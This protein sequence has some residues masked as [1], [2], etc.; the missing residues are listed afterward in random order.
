MN[1]NANN[2]LAI[3]GLVFAYMDTHYPMV[4][5]QKLDIKTWQHVV[6]KLPDL[7]ISKNVS[8]NYNNN[9]SGVSISGEFLSLVASAI[10]TDGASLLVDFTSFLNSV[11]DAVF[12]AQM[13]SESYKALTCTYQSYIKENALGGYFDY[14]AIVLRQIEFSEHFMELKG[15]CV[16]VK[17][18]SV[19]MSYVESTCLVQTS[20]IREGGHDYESFQSLINK[21]STEQFKKA[22]NFFNAP[23]TP[24]KGHYTYSQLD[25]HSAQVTR[26]MTQLTKVANYEPIYQD[27]CWCIC[28]D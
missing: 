21:K 6:G 26:K 22:K 20:R 3:G 23:S 11:G 24:P 17:S 14:G 27:L 5:S 28:C 2:L 25:R 18:V 16:D 15:V 10:I 1:E 7:A 9:I 8:K 12:S 19:S 4:S 13:T